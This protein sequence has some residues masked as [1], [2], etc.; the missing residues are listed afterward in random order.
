M[1]EF[2]EFWRE[3]P[4]KVG[5]MKAQ[6][7]WKKMTPQERHAALLVMRMWKQTVQWKA[8][9]GMYV[10]HGSTFLHQ[11]RYEDEPWTNAFAEVL[12]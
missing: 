12:R 2:E 6:Q 10:P 3:Y 4:R 5:R 1:P 11:R 8:D 9:G 7:C